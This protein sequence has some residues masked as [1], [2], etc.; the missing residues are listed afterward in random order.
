MANY[1]IFSTLSILGWW[2]LSYW[3]LRQEVCVSCFWAAGVCEPNLWRR[4]DLWSLGWP[5]RLLHWSR[6]MCIW[7][8]WPVAVL[9]W[10]KGGSGASGSISNGFLVQSRVS[11]LVPCGVR[12][13]CMCQEWFWLCDDGPCLLPGHDHHSQS[14]AQLGQWNINFVY[15]SAFFLV[16]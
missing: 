8:Q 2:S 15:I 16:H 4:R 1:L 5:K 9:W 11:R 14:Q 12:C 7:C 6:A 10:C 13:T 3:Q